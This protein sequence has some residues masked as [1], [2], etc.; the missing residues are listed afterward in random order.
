M[1][2]ENIRDHMVC[3]NYECIQCNYKWSTWYDKKNFS[4]DDVTAGY[5]AKDACYK[6]NKIN[7]PLESASS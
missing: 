5:R 3:I 6:C 7:S 1:T 4:F 2:E